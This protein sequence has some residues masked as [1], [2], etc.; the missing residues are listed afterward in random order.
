MGQHK[1]KITIRVSPQTA[2]HLAELARKC[3]ASEGQVVDALVAAYQKGAKNGH[4]EKTG[5]RRPGR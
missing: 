2:Y 5:P 1:Q 3:E 4:R